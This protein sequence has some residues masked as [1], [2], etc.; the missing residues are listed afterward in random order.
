[1]TEDDLLEVIELGFAEWVRS[2]GNGRL[3]DSDDPKDTLI[4]DSLKEGYV[5]G[6]CAAV[7]DVIEV[8]KPE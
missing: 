7:L 5:Q 2:S 8:L 1:M 3:F 4:L 6:Y